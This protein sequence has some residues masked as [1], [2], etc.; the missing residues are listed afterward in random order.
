MVNSCAAAGCTNRA[1]KNN[2]KAFHKFPI[3]NSELCKK[4]IVAMKRETFIPTEH[5]CI[6]SD[7][8]LPSDYNIPD[9]N[10]KTQLKPFCVPSI[11]IDSK[12]KVKRKFSSISP[13]T[14]KKRLI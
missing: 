5:S 7:H 8:F 9:F 6:C 1:M 11:T 10:N 3:S 14:N 4:W 12:P 13:Q 2:S